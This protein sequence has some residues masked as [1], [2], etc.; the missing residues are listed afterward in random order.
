MPLIFSLTQYFPPRFKLALCCHIDLRLS[1][2]SKLSVGVSAS[3]KID[4]SR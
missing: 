3:L 2:L 4:N 1:C